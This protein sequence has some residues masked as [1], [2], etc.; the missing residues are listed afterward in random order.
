MEVPE[1]GI[2][3]HCVKKYY[4]GRV[5]STCKS[6]LVKF[7][8]VHNAGSDKFNWPKR[9]D[10]D[11]VYIGSIF[12]GPVTLDQNIKRSIR[13]NLNMKIQFIQGQLTAAGIYQLICLLQYVNLWI[14]VLS[15]KSIET[16][17]LI[18]ICLSFKA[19]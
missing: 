12:Y 13:L 5:L 14:F 15:K 17:Y 6:N 4:I 2:V 9:N 8:F 1:D 18:L 11:E 3:V 16:T 19:I 10:I 7:I